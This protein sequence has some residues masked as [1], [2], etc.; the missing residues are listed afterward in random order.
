MIVPVF[1]C[2]RRCASFDGRPGYRPYA[3]VVPGGSQLLEVRLGP[4]AHKVLFVPTADPLVRVGWAASSAVK[5]ARS[6]RSSFRL[7]DAPLAGAKP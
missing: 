6:G 7:I 4:R 3:L 5:A 1:V 2:G